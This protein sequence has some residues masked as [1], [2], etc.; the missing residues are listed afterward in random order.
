MRD[1]E[2][3]NRYPCVKGMGERL[4]FWSHNAPETPLDSTS[5]KN[6]TEVAMVMSL[7]DYL[8]KQGY[9]KRQVRILAVSSTIFSW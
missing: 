2:S 4:F 6:D 7:L 5:R 1:H 3:V 9:E 8:M